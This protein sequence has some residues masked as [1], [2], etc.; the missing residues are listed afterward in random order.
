MVNG[1]LLHWRGRLG[2]TRIG[3]NFCIGARQKTA[4][5]L[6]EWASPGAQ[7]ALLPNS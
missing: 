3:A 6:Q 7:F 5:L 4:A 2:F 1:F